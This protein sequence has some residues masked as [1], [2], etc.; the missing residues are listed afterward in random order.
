MLQQH[1]LQ[2]QKMLQQKLQKAAGGTLRSRAAACA[3]MRSMRMKR[4]IS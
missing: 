2:Q 4:S 1:M 3:S